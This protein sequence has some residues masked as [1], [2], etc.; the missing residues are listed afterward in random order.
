MPLALSAYALV[1]LAT[2]KTALGIEPA[3]TSEDELLTYLINVATDRLEQDT[4]RPLH[5]RT[6]AYV[7]DGTGW[8]DLQ[9]VGYPITAVTLV[10]VN[11]SD[12]V[13]W[14]VTEDPAPVSWTVLIYPEIGRCRMPAGWP[15]GHANIRIEYDGG[16]GPTGERPIPSD[17]QEAA[18]LLTADAYQTRKQGTW[19]Q[20]NVAIAGQSWTLSP[21]ALWRRY[22]SC[23]N[24]YR[25]PPL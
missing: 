21:D 12:V 10:R 6:H 13:H 14:L 9:V 7:G 16:Y 19:N 4:G 15:A 22:R 3:T 18:V 2:V 17:L 25:N 1:D 24:P 11:D 5:W 23:M 8:R 20:A